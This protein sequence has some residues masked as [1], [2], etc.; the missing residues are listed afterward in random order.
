MTNIDIIKKSRD[1]LTGNWLNAIVIVIIYSLLTG[2]P[3]K[4][5]QNLSILTLL[6]GGALTLGLSYYFLNVV[7]NQNSGLE[8]L[9]D[10]FKKF[11]P[12]TVAFILTMI[13]CAIG[14]VLLI[15]PGIM[16]VCGLSQTFYIIAD[17]ENKI[18][19]VDAMKKSWDMMDGYKM[20]FFL[21]NL[22]HFGMIILGILM[23]VIGVFYMLPIIYA[24]LA[25]FYDQLKK[26]EL[27]TY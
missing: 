13:V 5:D 27:K 2:S 4:Y 22:I 26:G 9:F 24:S 16:L 25:L 15:I 12:S 7:R 6:I 10:G 20:K 19:G 14:F 11:A 23:L 17:D 21:L 8:D 18:S 3:S 1:L